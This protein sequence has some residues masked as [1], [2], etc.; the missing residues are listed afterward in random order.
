MTNENYRN[1]NTR[2]WEP[3]EDECIRD[4]YGKPG[5]SAQ[6]LGDRLGRT[7]HSIIGRA[8]R[9]GI[10]AQMVNVGGTMV[11]IQAPLKPVY[12]PPSP[13][14]IRLAEFDPVVARALKMREMENAA[15]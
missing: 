8:H 13:H 15:A 1:R 14:M 5:I 9:L 3:E 7:R 4:L 10:A 11:R 2:A 6:A 12:A